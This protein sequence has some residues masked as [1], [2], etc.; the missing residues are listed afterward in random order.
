MTPIIKIIEGNPPI[1]DNIFMP[2]IPLL[3]DI[4]IHVR[5]P[6]TETQVVI[7]YLGGSGKS[8]AMPLLQRLDIDNVVES[9]AVIKEI[10]TAIKN[11]GVKSFFK[12][13]LLN[14]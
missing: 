9:K 4:V 6:I 2:V 13:I 5:I 12:W 14:N 10:N 8:G 11:K 3:T 1:V 7:R